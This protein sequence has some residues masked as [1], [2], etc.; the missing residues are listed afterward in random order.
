MTSLSDAERDACDVMQALAGLAA[1]L[2]RP[3]GDV[4]AVQP[5]DPALGRAQELLLGLA[6]DAGQACERVVSY[7]REQRGAGDGEAVAVPVRLGPWREW[8]PERGHLFGV[9]AGVRR[10]GG[11]PQVRRCD[12]GE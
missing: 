4:P 8:A 9:S 7:L 1:L 12:P 6:E 11:V 10:A 5:S 2:R 3:T